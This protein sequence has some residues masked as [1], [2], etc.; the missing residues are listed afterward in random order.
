M[1]EGKT[2]NSAWVVFAIQQTEHQRSSV[3]QAFIFASNLRA[4]PHHE[5]R[6]PDE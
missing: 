5:F 3:G 2:A 6:Q 1:G 4:V